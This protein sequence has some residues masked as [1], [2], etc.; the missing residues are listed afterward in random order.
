M[1]GA[2]HYMTNYLDQEGYTELIN[3]VL[4]CKLDN[5]RGHRLRVTHRVRSGHVCNANGCTSVYIGFQYTHPSPVSYVLVIS[6]YKASNVQHTIIVTLKT[7]VY[8]RL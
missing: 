5:L 1:G 3:L 6:E 8:W 2:I 7:A 4:M